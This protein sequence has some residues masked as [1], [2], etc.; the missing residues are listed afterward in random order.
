MKKL[1]TLMCV[2]ALGVSVI[3]PNTILAHESVEGEV[4]YRATLL[5]LINL[6]EQQIV[7]LQAE[8]KG[9][10]LVEGGAGNS[11]LSKAVPI[12]ANYFVESPA[13]VQTIVNQSHQEYF[14]RVF[15]IFPPEYGSKIRQL[16]VF[17]GEDL[18]FDAFVETL[19]PDNQYW[20]YAVHEGMLDELDSRFNIELIIHELA[21]IVSYEESTG[22]ISST[23]ISCSAYFQTYGCPAEDS[24]LNQ[25]V[26]RFWSDD[27][28]SRI[29][30]FSDATNPLSLIKNYYRQHK[31]EFVTGYAAKGPEE[32]FAESF[33]YY[34]INE[35]V[36]GTEVK[37]K[38]DFFSEYQTLV[39]VR[40]QILGNI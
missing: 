23:E 35:P 16:K 34:V 2:M 39:T 38:V 31:T 15:E 40:N 17:G 36:L 8:L 20:S 21:H 27:D 7:V 32:D 29:V 12:R 13:E 28:L 30:Q 22:V 9:R 24:Y 11:F 1:G 4:S 6:L 33:L 25:F 18:E 37:Q 26:E 10:S 14:K 19:P 3:F 5:E